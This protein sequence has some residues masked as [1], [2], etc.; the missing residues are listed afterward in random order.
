[1]ASR[2]A[3]YRYRGESVVGKMEAPNPVHLL[4]ADREQRVWVFGAEGVAVA[5][6]AAHEPLLQEGVE[7]ALQRFA[8]DTETAL[9]LDEAGTASFAEQCQRRRR[10]AMVKEVDQ[11]GG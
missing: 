1:M 2:D 5:G 8:P 9:Q 3:L 11:L 4:F 6:I 10:P 7:R